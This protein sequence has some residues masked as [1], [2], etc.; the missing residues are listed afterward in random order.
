[1]QLSKFARLI[2][3]SILAGVLVAGC[4]NK[5]K[6]YLPEKTENPQQT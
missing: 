1:M 4:G 6:L 5:G 3:V 2:V